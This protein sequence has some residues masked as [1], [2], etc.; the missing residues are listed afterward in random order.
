MVDSTSH[1]PEWQPRAVTKHQKKPKP[2]SHLGGNPQVERERPP[3]A[4]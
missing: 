1:I 4:W 2:A 3:L